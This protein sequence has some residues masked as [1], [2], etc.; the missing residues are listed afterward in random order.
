MPSCTWSPRTGTRGGS[1]RRACRDRPRGTSAPPRRVYASTVETE[2]AG[3]RVMRWSTL[4]A[5][6]AAA[7]TLWGA[8]EGVGP[9]RGLAGAVVSGD[10]QPRYTA[11]R[12]AEGT[13]VRAVTRG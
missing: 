8:A 10:G 11:S 2:G 5:G 1:R 6:A 4:V 3:M 7:L 9:W 13:V 12:T